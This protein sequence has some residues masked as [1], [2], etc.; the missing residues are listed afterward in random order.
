MAEALLKR[1]IGDRAF[2]D[3]C[4]V[5]LDPRSPTDEGIDPFAASV[6]AELSC[7]LSDYQ[8][9]TFESLNPDAFDLVVSLTPQAQQRAKEMTR[10][11]AVE[12]E[13]WP[14]ADPTQSDGSREARL[15][16]YRQVRDALAERIA[17]RFGADYGKG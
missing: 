9:K 12:I 8:P 2:V 11:R 3:S 15:A 17:L 1:L 6:M 4:G 16:V 7:S 10:G 14:L 13:Y 5:R